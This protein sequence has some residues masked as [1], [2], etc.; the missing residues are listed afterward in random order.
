[1]GSVM[2]FKTNSDYFPKQQN[3]LTYAIG[4]QCFL[5]HE[6]TLCY[7]DEAEALNGQS[8]IHSTFPVTP[9]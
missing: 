6:M 1:M 9:I 4:M 3:H 7:S 2:I 8:S 5:K